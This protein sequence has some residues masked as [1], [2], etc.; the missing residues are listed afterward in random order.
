MVLLRPKIQAVEKRILFF[1]YFISET[2]N[3]SYIKYSMFRRSNPL[4]LRTLSSV[5]IHGLNGGIYTPLEIPTSNFHIWNGL[6]T[7]RSASP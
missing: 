1:S 3:F 5:Y 2:P 6:E 7:R 4:T